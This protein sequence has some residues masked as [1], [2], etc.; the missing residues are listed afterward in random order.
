MH[1]FLE[2][3]LDQI[4]KALDEKSPEAEAFLFDIAKAA[5]LEEAEL[6]DGSVVKLNDSN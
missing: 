2:Q 4:I 3:D 1:K 5:G 6:F